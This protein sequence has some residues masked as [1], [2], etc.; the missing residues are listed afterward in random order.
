MR[1]FV[2]TIRVLPFALALAAAPLVAQQGSVIDD[3]L[4]RANDA[5]NDLN[6]Q[7]AD[8]FAQQVLMSTGTVTS[9]QRTR[10]LVIIAAAAYP[11]DPPAQRRA[12]ALTTLRSLVRM[13][14]DVAIPN[15]LNWPGLD[16][17]VA[18]AKR[19]TF[20]IAVSGDSLQTLVGP[21]GVGR[22][23][24]RSSRPGK[25]SLTIMQPGGAGL[26]VVDSAPSALTGE[27]R[28][29]AMRGDRP[30]FTTGDY[31]V[32]VT[33]ID[34]NGRDTVTVRHTARIEVPALDFVT[35][36]AKMDSS[37]LLRIRTP[38][39]GAKSIFPAIL[40]GGGAYA[41]ASVLR[42]QGGIM[43]SVTADP[44]GVAVGGAIAFSTILAGFADRGRPLPANVAANNAFGEAFQKSIVDAQAENRRRI[45]EH[46]TIVR[47]AL[48]AR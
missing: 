32:I 18:E 43:D 24:V 46:R 48:E 11:D 22:L 37:K 42:A 29:N 40:V 35:V 26:V 41:L 5:Y 6:W 14:L 13:N 31:T 33:G 20:G 21:Q 17:L 4:K 1:R 27:F 38:R 45:A 44:K 39:F 2:A 34:A 8:G 9:A 3:L 16:S 12:V 15:E 25:F 19:T 10:A 23:A 7:R 36:P 30:I 47:F 28:F